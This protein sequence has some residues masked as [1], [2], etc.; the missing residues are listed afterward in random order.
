MHGRHSFNE[1]KQF[2]LFED[3]TDAIVNAKRYTIKHIVMMESSIVEFHQVFY[4]PAIQKLAFHLPHLCI[5]GTNHCGNTYQEAFD[6]RSEF[7]DVLC[8]SDYSERVVSI[9]S[10]QIQYEYYG[11]NRSVSIKGIAWE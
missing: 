8:C 4:I 5:I 7:Q 6:R 1:N 2:P 10:Q 11:D 3:S 9:F